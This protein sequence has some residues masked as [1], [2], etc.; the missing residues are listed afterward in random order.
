MKPIFVFGLIL[1]ALDTV[2]AI[3]WFGFGVYVV[4]SDYH[5]AQ[6]YFVEHMLLLFHILNTVVIYLALETFRSI[7]TCRIPYFADYRRTGYMAALFFVLCVCLGSGVLSLVHI[8][9][10]HNFAITA[11]IGI[12]VQAVV[13]V[14]HV[15]LTIGWAILLH[16]H[17]FHYKQDVLLVQHKTM[18]VQS[19][20]ATA[21]EPSGNVGPCYRKKK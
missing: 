3:A 12:F 15:I 5:Y 2:W 14:A 21:V 18:M 19:G 11:Y 20:I 7:K 8:S 9:L 16:R 1:A 17:L 13:A 6:T 4:V 10:F